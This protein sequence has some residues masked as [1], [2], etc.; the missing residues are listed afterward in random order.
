MLTVALA[1]YN[2]GRMKRYL[3]ELFLQQDA[4][5]L[6]EIMRRAETLSGTPKENGKAFQPVACAVLA[7]R[8]G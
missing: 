4:D 3:C 6:R 1:R 7:E 5:T 8:E 2:N